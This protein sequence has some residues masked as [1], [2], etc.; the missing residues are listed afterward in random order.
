M[1]ATRKAAV[2]DAFSAAVMVQLLA[3]PAHVPLQLE[4]AEPA[5]GLTVSATE[6]PCTN[7]A[8]QVAG[9]SIPSGELMTVPLP[10]PDSCTV[11][12]T[13][14]ELL[15]EPAL[16][17]LLELPQAV[18][19]KRAKIDKWRERSPFMSI[20]PISSSGRQMVQVAAALYSS[21]GGQ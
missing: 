13:D 7:S 9:Q 2:T 4:N 16:D 11:S 10:S 1:L 21:R 15:L 8:L 18:K 6:V 3:A 12:C 14:E 19:I 5:A 17:G 20:L